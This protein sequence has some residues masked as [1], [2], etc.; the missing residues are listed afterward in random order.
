[1][2]SIGSPPTNA[3]AAVLEQTASC[4]SPALASAQ[5]SPPPLRR[6]APPPAICEEEASLT[7]GGYF[8]ADN[9]DGTQATRRPSS[10]ASLLT[11]GQNFFG[12]DA[13]LDVKVALH[14]ARSA[15]L[16]RPRA[17]GNWVQAFALHD[18]TG[19]GLLGRSEFEAFM[20]SLDLK[21]SRREISSL[22]EHLLTRRGRAISLGDFSDAMTH[23]V[24]EETIRQDEDWAAG[25]CCGL[26]AGGAATNA[27]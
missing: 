3:A 5:V 23:C 20:A 14:R 2:G 11:S 15:L 7:N 22:A 26:L 27:Q 24:P 13:S 10:A 12:E 21:L 9:P 19:Q 6:P 4:W 8:G 25:L 16:R 1:M 17:R 18:S